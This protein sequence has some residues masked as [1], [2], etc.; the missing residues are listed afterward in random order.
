MNEEQ[1]SQC[2]LG[3]LCMYDLASWDLEVCTSYSGVTITLKK[4]ELFEA[5]FLP[6]RTNTLAVL[7]EIH[8]MCAY[9]QKSINNKK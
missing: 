2:L 4:G 8:D 9:V 7:D 6:L 3:I 5:R 1:G